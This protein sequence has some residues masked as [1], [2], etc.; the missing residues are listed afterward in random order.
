MTSQGKLQELEGQEIS[1]RRE[2]RGI[3]KVGEKRERKHE[4]RE[5]KRKKNSE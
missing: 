5:R 4:Q 2:E 1:R 3:K